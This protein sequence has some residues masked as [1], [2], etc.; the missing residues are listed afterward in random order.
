M[1]IEEM[2]KIKFFFYKNEMDNFINKEIFHDKINE[3]SFNNINN[4]NTLK[5][6]INSF[7]DKILQNEK[8]RESKIV[9]LLN[10]FI[11]QKIKFNF[12]YDEILACFN[13]YLLNKDIY[14]ELVN[15][16]ENRSEPYFNVIRKKWIELKLKEEK[17]TL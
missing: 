15:N 3:L 14:I 12:N 9:E 4:Y 10:F 1:F 2:K 7:E 11:S 13:V 17:K 5:N 8:D 16:L 6:A